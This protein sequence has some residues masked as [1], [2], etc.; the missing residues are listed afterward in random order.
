MP[1]P[2]SVIASSTI[3][4]PSLLE[5]RTRGRA[6]K[7]VAAD[8]GG[9]TEADEPA[10]VAD[11][12]RLCNAFVPTEASGALAQ[13]FGEMTRGE[14]DVPFG[15]DL[16][17][18]SQPK[19]HRIEPEGFGQFIHRAF[20][21]QDADRVAWSAH[22]IRARQIQ[23]CQAMPGK[24]V[25]RGIEHA[26]CSAD[27]LDVLVEARALHQ[28]ILAIGGQSAVA[29][30]AEPQPLLGCGAMGGQ[31]KE[32][33]A[34]HRHFHRS[35][36]DAGTDGR[37]RR[38]DIERQLAA[39]AA[40]DVTGNDADI[41]L[42]NVECPGEAFLWACRQLRRR[43]NRQHLALPRRHRRMRLH[44]GL[45]LIGCGVDRLDLHRRSSERGFEIADGTV[46]GRAV[47]DL[48]W[49]FGPRPG[50]VQVVLAGQRFVAD[51]NQRGGG[52]GLLEC[53]GDHECDGE[54]EITHRIGIE[55]GLGAGKTV[56][57]IDRAPRALRWRI[58][59]G[60]HQQHSGSALCVAAT[61]TAT[62]RPLAIAAGTMTP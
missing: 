32:L 31:V 30:G 57:Q 15:I 47:A 21:R 49:V 59:F 28:R 7:Y 6:P 53:F 44:G 58:V 25:G 37:E 18:V 38:V 4:R 55:R 62:T 27:R 40:A 22:R 36:K 17:V 14:G 1:V 33:G 3:S 10:P 50:C 19:L 24:P 34:G 41:L 26:G 45:V 46:G 13:R 11:T 48:A 2:I 54:A 61:S 29:V 23:L 39:E 60:Q 20:E 9:D 42:G 16:C 56:R 51:M 12:G 52:R 8:R 5:A 43:M 35:T